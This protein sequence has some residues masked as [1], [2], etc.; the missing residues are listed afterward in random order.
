[1]SRASGTEPSVAKLAALLGDLTLEVSSLRGRI[2]TLEAGGFEVVPPETATS[3]PA[4]S[5]AGYRVGERRVSI[6]RNIGA[7]LRRALDGE[8]RGQ[9]GR[10]EIGLGSRLY[11]VC[12]DIEGAVRNPPLVFFSWQSAKSHCVRQGEPG[13][14]VFIGL[15]TKAEA[16]IAVHSAGLSIPASLRR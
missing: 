9:S 11:L 8:D 7:W 15:P 5:E 12:R 14:S 13:D 16:E 1:M 10:S 4:S 6:A 3:T 2:E